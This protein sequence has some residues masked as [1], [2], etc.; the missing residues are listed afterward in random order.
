MVCWN[1]YCH[2]LFWGLRSDGK[3]HK[4]LSW[5]SRL[6]P[7]VMF[8]TPYPRQI[9]SEWFVKCVDRDEWLEANVTLRSVFVTFGGRRWECVNTEGRQTTAD[10][11]TLIT[12]GCPCPVS[13]LCTICSV[14]SLSRV[15]TSTQETNSDSQWHVRRPSPDTCHI[16]G[17]S[18]QGMFLETSILVFPSESVWIVNSEDVSQLPSPNNRLQIV[19]VLLFFTP[20]GPETFS[21]GSERVHE[22]NKTLNRRWTSRPAE[23]RDSAGLCEANQSDSRGK[24]AFFY[25]NEALT[26]NPIWVLPLKVFSLWNLHVSPP[27]V[28]VDFLWKL[29]FLAGLVRYRNS[30]LP[31]GVDV[32]MLFLW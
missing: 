26:A 30:K 22:V 2:H 1:V 17:E 12:A 23:P 19:K 24:F 16:T 28:C 9:V 14:L 3:L 25:G 5:E 18:F 32:W 20:A 10:L 13:S 27:R 4:K 29:Q 8:V 31:S 21:S 11:S 7:S 6:S 15:V